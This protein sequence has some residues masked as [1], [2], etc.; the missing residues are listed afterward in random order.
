M[1]SLVL[2]MTEPQSRAMQRVA[3]EDF[4]NVKF[5][6]RRHHR[7]LGIE[8]DDEYYESGCAALTQYYATAIFDPKSVHAISEEL[9]DFW[10]SHIV[11]TVPYQMLA[12]DLGL[13]MHHDPLDN[14][15]KEKAAHVERVYRYTRDEVL[16]RLFSEG[17]L[18]SRFHP[19]ETSLVCLHDVDCLARE[20]LADT[21]FDPPGDI[22]EVKALYGHHRRAN[23][24]GMR[25][26]VEK[27]VFPPSG[28]WDS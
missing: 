5:L 7:K 11:D 20:L 9:D 24:L 26:S 8:H 3:A 27:K 17:S 14:A 15:D 19:H 25:L 13:F 23:E 4:E 1:E 21:P 6:T 2:D 28:R 18:D 12:Q 10:H 22:L 16:P